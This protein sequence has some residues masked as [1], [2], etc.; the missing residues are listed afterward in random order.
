MEPQLEWWK[1]FFSGLWGNVLRQAWTPEQTKADAEFIEQLLQVLPPASILDVPCGE[2]R[3]A[4]VLASRGYDVTGVDG[5]ASFLDTARR[6]AD[7]QHLSIHWEPRDMREL[8]WQDTFD[9]ALCFWG[10]FGYFD[11]AGNEQFLRA[12]CRALKP[13]GRFVLETLIAETLLPQFQERGWQ[14]I[15]DTLLLERRWYDY[16]QSRVGTEWT[17]IHD[18]KTET[19]T[20]SIRIYTYRELCELFRRV[21][22]VPADAYDTRSRQPFAFGA[23]RVTIVARKPAEKNT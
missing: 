20:T 7:E 2:G 13:G 15:G 4:R 5:T 19:Q 18:S 9:G 10:S 8:V 22:L 17:F 6:Y 14:Q 21:G 3:I 1:P 12:V 11:D 16:A 23:R